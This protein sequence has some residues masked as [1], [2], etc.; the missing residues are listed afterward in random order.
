MW[1]RIGNFTSLFCLLIISSPGWGLADTKTLPTNTWMVMQPGS[2]DHRLPGTRGWYQASYD[3]VFRETVI[4]GGS[5]STY[6]SDTWTYSFDDNL[7][8]LRR[9]HP[10]LQGP[11]RRD[12]QNLLYDPR[13]KVHWLFNGI[14]YDNM[15]PGCA[16]FMT[17]AG[18]WTYNRAEN[19][20]TKLHI[21]G[22]HLRLAPGM[23]YNNDTHTFL[24][25]GGSKTN[26]TNTTYLFDI[27]TRTWRQ[28]RPPVAPAPRLNIE[29]SLVYDKAHHVFVLFGGKGPLGDTWLFDPSTETWREVTPPASPP[30]RDLHAMVYDDANQVVLLFG[31][32][33]TQEN[34][35]NDT[36]IY[37]VKTNVWTQLTQVGTPP[38]MAH[39]AAVYDP[40]HGVVI[41]VP[42]IGTVHTLA[43]KYQP[44]AALPHPISLP[45]GK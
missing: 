21:P 27:A 28:L 34:L 23:A 35:L 10:D 11:C 6:M 33:A 1:K 20:W 17:H 5:A 8:S 19:A 13:D 31:G 39:H 26:P 18:I 3:P 32:R 14:A 38:A 15:Q 24:E 44:D 7:W 30:A 43:F 22:E 4:F 9:S 16:G 36:W 37:D 12:M 29:N 41:V 25:F 45:T 42:G 2:A 40:L